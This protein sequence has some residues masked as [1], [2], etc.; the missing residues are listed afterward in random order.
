MTRAPSVGFTLPCWSVVGSKAARN[1][2]ITHQNMRLNR[3]TKNTDDVQYHPGRK[4]NCSM[5]KLCVMCSHNSFPQRVLHS[6][7]VLP[8]LLWSVN[9]VSH[10]D[11]VDSVYIP[12]HQPCALAPTRLASSQV[13]DKVMRDF[14]QLIRGEPVSYFIHITRLA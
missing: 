1:K 12:G 5:H 11:D 2:A 4:G 9:I 8:R 3:D 7:C 14:V 6:D 10:P 13:G